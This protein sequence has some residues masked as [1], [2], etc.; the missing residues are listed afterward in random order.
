MLLEKRRTNFEN[1]WAEIKARFSW[2]FGSEHKETSGFFINAMTV[3]DNLLM[4]GI[5]F[6][7][8]ADEIFRFLSLCYDR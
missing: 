8:S 1:K 6:E 4:L 5:E 3:S 2:D 7:E